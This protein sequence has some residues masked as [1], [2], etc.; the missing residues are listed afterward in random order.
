[1]DARFQGR[2]P[3]FH[4]GYAATTAETGT[5]VSFSADA[6]RL[7]YL[8]RHDSPE[9]PTE[10]WRDDLDSGKSEVVFS[11]QPAGQ[12]SQLWLAPLDR[13]APPRRIETALSGSNGTGWR[14][15]DEGGALSGD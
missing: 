6:K 12:A 2:P 5:P 3:H 13:R 10:L 4:E 14:R 7:Y 8:L 9:S 15:P 1:V 11:T